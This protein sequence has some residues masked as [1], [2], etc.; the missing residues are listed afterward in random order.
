MAHDEAE[1]AQT[2][3]THLQVATTEAATQAE[4]DEPTSCLD[5]FGSDDDDDDDA[6]SGVGGGVGNDDDSNANEN[7]NYH[8]VCHVDEGDDDDDDDDD[9]DAAW[10]QLEHSL[11]NEMQQLQAMSP[12]HR[13]QQPEDADAPRGAR[14]RRRACAPS[15]AA[16][17]SVTASPSPSPSPQRRWAAAPRS[18]ACGTCTFVNGRG[19]RCAMC[20]GLRRETTG[21]GDAES[22]APPARDDG[23]GGEEDDF[24]D[25]SSDR[26]RRKRKKAARRQQKAQPTGKRKREQNGEATGAAPARDATATLGEQAGGEPAVQGRR[27]ASHALMPRT[28]RRPEAPDAWRFPFPVLVDPGRLELGE[29][30]VAQTTPCTASLG[31]RRH[32]P[33]CASARGPRKRAV[34]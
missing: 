11:E 1:A 16:A 21:G 18:W 32:A 26:K 15:P 23:G 12:S 2:E 7:D 31:G 5:L 9:E 24:S 22:E 4:A 8:V 30:I 27:R 19:F 10:A 17:A 34:K 13:P 29:A 25:D 14:G 3:A 28:D 20:G 6:G 33:R